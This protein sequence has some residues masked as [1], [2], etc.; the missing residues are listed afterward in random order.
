[1]PRGTPW[2]VQDLEAAARA[3]NIS[4]EILEHPVWSKSFVKSFELFETIDVHGAAL[5]WLADIGV[6][7]FIIQN[8]W[9][10]TLVLEDHVDWPIK[11][12]E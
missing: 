5:A 2:R 1:V 6:L 10:F 4:L 12:H 7:K 11:V 8:P 3:S 9:G